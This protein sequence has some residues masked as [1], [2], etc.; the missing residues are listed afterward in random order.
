[1]KEKLE[2][3]LFTGPKQVF[4]HFYTNEKFVF[5]FNCSNWEKFVGKTGEN[6]IRALEVWCHEQIIT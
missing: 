3:K 1:M 4:P 2:N 5:F 6:K